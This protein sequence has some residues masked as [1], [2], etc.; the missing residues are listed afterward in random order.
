MGTCMLLFFPVERFMTIVVN[1]LDSFALFYSPCIKRKLS[2]CIH[3]KRLRFVHFY[4]VLFTI[5]AHMSKVFTALHFSIDNPAH[6][7]FNFVQ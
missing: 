7:F 6:N 5:L 2:F 1:T 3:I 4:R